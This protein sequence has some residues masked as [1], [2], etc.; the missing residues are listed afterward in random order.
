MGSIDLSFKKASTYRAFDIAT[1]DLAAHSQ[2]SGQF[3][4]IH[5][6]DHG[7]PLKGEGKVVGDIGVGG[8]SGEQD[9]AFVE[10]GAEAFQP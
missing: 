8:G 9:H 6:P 10:A 7:I 3:V 4:G 5:A 1:K 2:S